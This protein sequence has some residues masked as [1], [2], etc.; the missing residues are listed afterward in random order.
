MHVGGIGMRRQLN[1]G[2]PPNLAGSR[3]RLRKSRTQ[4]AR[5]C[6]SAPML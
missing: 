1:H 3:Q 2:G 4:E 5:P 6:G